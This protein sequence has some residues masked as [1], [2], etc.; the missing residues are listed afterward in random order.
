M[1]EPTVSYISAKI[2]SMLGG[3]FGGSAILTFI[4]PKTITEAFT[5]GVVSVGAAIIF[6][7]SLLEVAKLTPSV[8]NYAMSGFCV[9]FVSYSL[10]GMIANFLYKHE[11]DDIV[12]VVNDIRG[13]NDNKD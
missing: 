1:P 8:E 5:R 13:K 3:F 6:S 7:S 11:K 12:S 4:K 2:A 10:L 9:G